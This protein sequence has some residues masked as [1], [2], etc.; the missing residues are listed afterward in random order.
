MTYYIL[1][2]GR[3]TGPLTF[4]QL[5]SYSIQPDTKVWRNDLPNWVE[6]RELDELKE[7]LGY[8][9]SSFSRQNTGYTAPPASHASG[10]FDTFG[11]LARL[12]KNYQWMIGSIITLL[13]GTLFLVFASVAA[14][15]AERY[16]DSYAR[17]GSFMLIAIL[18]FLAGVVLT[19]VFFCK[20][21]YAYWT[22][23]QDGSQKPSPGEAVGFL[24]I[25][26]FNFYW[27][28]V[29]FNR[30]S[31]ELNKKADM[32]DPGG[33][34]RADEGTSLTY[35]ILNI[36]TIIPFLGYLASLVNIILFF[37]IMGNHKKVVHRIANGNALSF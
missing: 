24:F 34:Q 30:L 5:R 8:S 9:P 27:A 36:C 1:I 4:D 35:C 22:I 31:K 15:A 23:V 26:L 13:A 6:A 18:I 2:N 28:F 14:V 17:V 7:L 25:P 11:F 32:V 12:D 10:N 16:D 33:Y 37:I 20:V 3:E 21:Q 29:S 19:I